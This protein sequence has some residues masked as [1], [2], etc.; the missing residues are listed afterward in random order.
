MDAATVTGVG[1][2]LA[3]GAAYVIPKVKAYLDSRKSSSLPHEHVKSLIDYFTGKKCKKGVDATVT[4][5][6]LLYEECTDHLEDETPT[7]I[8]NNLP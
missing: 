8:V 5:G 1:L 2:V 7:P 3:T 4:V 6:K